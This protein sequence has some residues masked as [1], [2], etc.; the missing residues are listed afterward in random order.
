MKKI[1]KTMALI[2]GTVISFRVQSV[3]AAVLVVANPHITA[4][5]SGAGAP[6]GRGITRGVLPVTGWGIPLVNTADNGPMLRTAIP[7][8]GVPAVAPRA[9]M[10]VAAPANSGLTAAPQAEDD[11]VRFQAGTPATAG[12]LQVMR[13]LTADPHIQAINQSGV[14]DR[15][16]ASAAALD[17]VFDNVRTPLVSGR[18]QS[19][20]Q[21]DVA[22]KPIA[23][24]VRQYLQGQ[25]WNA[26]DTGEIGRKT[27]EIVNLAQDGRTFA[28]AVFVAMTEVDFSY[29]RQDWYDMD[30]LESVWA[31]SHQLELTSQDVALIKEG[32]RSSLVQDKGRI[33]VAPYLLRL[34]GGGPDVTI[35]DQV[36]KY[37]QGQ[38]WNAEDTG[39][40]GR[41][42]AKIVNLA[43]DGRTFARA[44]FVAMT[45]VDFS[46][47]R[48][49]W[50]DM[51]L[52]ESVWARSHQLE[53]TSQDVALVKEGLRS[54]LAQ[55]ERRIRVAPYL[56]VLWG[57]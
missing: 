28:R 55:D 34:W 30:L 7:A 12:A 50:Y 32:L 40:I 5:R 37:L 51:D 45:E 21:P 18:T 31:R 42:T 11:E 20:V 9:E 10:G 36:R 25:K 33:R 13:S 39:K 4:I 17:R 44:V 41:K 3:S 52:L 1:A 14:C 38:K 48:Q 54:S 29:E 8:V 6:A 47:E 24:Q 15:S 23:D 43:Q 27:A 49:D 19:E 56:R 22:V 35:A 26:E 53:L 2:V 46:Y 16:G 57:R